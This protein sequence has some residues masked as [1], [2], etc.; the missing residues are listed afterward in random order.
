MICRIQVV[1]VADLLKAVKFVH[2]W[3]IDP[4][5][6]RPNSLAT[7]KGILDTKL[8]FFVHEDE[9]RRVCVRSRGSAIVLHWDGDFLHSGPCVLC[10]KTPFFWTPRGVLF[11]PEDA[12]IIE[13]RPLCKWCMKGDVETLYRR[14]H[15]RI[16]P[17]SVW[18]RLDDEESDALFE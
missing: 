6:L 9:G 8:P 5:T 11:D 18:D 13:G 1:A 3:S 16:Q 17:P 4:E 15:R 14:I 7:S 2:D 10:G 12:D